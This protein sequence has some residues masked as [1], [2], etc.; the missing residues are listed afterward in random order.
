MYY[1]LWRWYAIVAN[2]N[3][4]IANFLTDRT[5]SVVVDGI[6]SSKVPITSRVPQGS[7]LGP[8]FFIIK[9]ILQI[10]W[11]RQ[12]TFSLTTHY[13]CMAVRRDHDAEVLQSDIDKL[14]VW[15][16]RWMMQFHPDKCEVITISRKRKHNYTMHGHRLKH[17][18]SIT[19]QKHWC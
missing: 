9:T 14:I 6:S 8:C 18:G 10:S 7:V 2:V 16:N 13:T 1:Y 11:L 5:Q 19:L 4:W 17:V 12:H 3:T 15:E